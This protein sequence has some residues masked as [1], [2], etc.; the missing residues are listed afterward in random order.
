MCHVRCVLWWQES[1]TAVLPQLTLLASSKC[2]SEQCFCPYSNVKWTKFCIVGR[3]R[4]HLLLEEAEIVDS[5]YFKENLSAKGLPRLCLVFLSCFG[6]L[7]WDFFMAAPG[8]VA[9]SCLWWLK[10]QCSGEMGVWA[11]AGR[12]APP[13]TCC[14]WVCSVLLSCSIAWVLQGWAEVQ[15]SVPEECAFSLPA[16]ISSHPM[17]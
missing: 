9:A 3:A 4:M 15:H 6:Q 13:G 12:K 7:G 2:A 16:S 10:K 5:L 8:S 17:G 11:R 1:S 14:R